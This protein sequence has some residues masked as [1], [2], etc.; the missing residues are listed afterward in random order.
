MKDRVPRYKAVDGEAVWAFVKMGHTVYSA[1]MTSASAI[2]YNLIASSTRMKRAG[3]VTITRG[4]NSQ[5]GRKLIRVL[6][7]FLALVYVHNGTVIANSG[8]N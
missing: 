4:K 6:H 2:T 8:N 1:L 7:T 3:R 5:R